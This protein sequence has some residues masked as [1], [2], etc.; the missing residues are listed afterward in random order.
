MELPPR[1]LHIINLFRHGNFIFLLA[2]E[3]DIIKPVSWV[4]NAQ[5]FQASLLSIVFSG[6]CGL[7]HKDGLGLGIDNVRVQSAFS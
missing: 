6:K 2:G 5:I 7:N 1:F 4:L 3:S